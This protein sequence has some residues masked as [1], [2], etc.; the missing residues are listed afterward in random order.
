MG[1]GTLTE[2][3]NE[4]ISERGKGGEREK[5]ETN[6]ELKERANHSSNF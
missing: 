4:T 3:I 6:K 1:G 5:C 2:E